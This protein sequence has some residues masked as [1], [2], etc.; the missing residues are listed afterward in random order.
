[1]EKHKLIAKGIL[2]WFTALVV[3]ISL[4]SIDSILEGGFAWFCT[5]IVINMVLIVA[6]FYTITE[7]E[8]KILSGYNILDKAF[9]LED[10]INY[11]NQ[12]L[13]ILDSK[14]ITP[15]NKNTVLGL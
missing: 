12:L 8:Y 15:V 10:Q 2:L 3:L 11:I 5:I 14:F 4:F 1:M 13:F 9:K 7:E 6:C